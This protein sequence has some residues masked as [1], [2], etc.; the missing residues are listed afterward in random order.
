M[1]NYA[2]F[3][4][5][6]Y[7]DCCY[8]T[9]ISLS[10]AVTHKIQLRRVKLFARSRTDGILKWCLINCHTFCTNPQNSQEHYVCY[11][12]QI[13]WNEALWFNTLKDAC[14]NP[15]SM[16]PWY[17]LNM[18]AL[19][20]DWAISP[21]QQMI[22]WCVGVWA[23]RKHLNRKL[24]MIVGPLLPWDPKRGIPIDKQYNNISYIDILVVRAGL[25]DSDAV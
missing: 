19:K 21:R 20:F 3:S 1:S 7:S 18:T 2:I 4:F 17:L 6:F 22:Y 16:V 14:L 13:N 12:Y 23:K 11:G 25:A 5:L 10:N 9:L 24:S 8:T 15:S